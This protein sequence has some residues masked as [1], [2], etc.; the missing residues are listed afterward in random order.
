MKTLAEL[1]E[2]EI[3][4]LAIS[5]EEEDSRIYMTFAEDLTE[6]YPAS[7]KMFVE[8]AAEEEGRGLGIRCPIS[9]PTHGRTPFGSR[10]ASRGSWSS[11]SFGRSPTCAHDT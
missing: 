6:R 5:S 1:T 11:S 8:M 3:L 7:A 4:A 10:Q 2:R 9:F